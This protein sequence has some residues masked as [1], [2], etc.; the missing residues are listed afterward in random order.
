MGSHDNLDLIKEEPIQNIV[1]YVDKFFTS[2]LP[3]M[4]ET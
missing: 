4:R 1:D 3:K 2:A